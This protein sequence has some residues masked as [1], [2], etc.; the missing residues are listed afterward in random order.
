MLPIQQNSV[1]LFHKNKSRWMWIHDAGERLCNETFFYSDG[2]FSIPT[3]FLGTTNF[4]TVFH[5]IIGINL[6]VNSPLKF[7]CIHT[8][9]T[10][11]GDLCRLNCCRLVKIVLSKFSELSLYAHLS[12]IFLSVYGKGFKLRIYYIIVGHI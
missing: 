10:V 8:K 7:I 1:Q 9:S 2:N 3:I 11:T 4:Q 5:S 12:S 6:Q